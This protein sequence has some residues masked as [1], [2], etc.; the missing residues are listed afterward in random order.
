MLK[1]LYLVRYIDDIKASLGNIVILMADNIQADKII[2]RAQVGESLNRLLSQNY[3]GRSGDSYHF[4]TDEEQDIQKEIKA[5]MVDTSNIVGKIAHMI[6]GAIYE[7]KKF[8]YGKYDFAFD[9][10][11]DSIAVGAVTGGMR[12]RIITVAVDKTEKSELRMMAES[13]G[14]AIVVLSETPY[15]DSLECAEKIRK[16]IKQKI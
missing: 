11:V 7:T 4:L 1:L 14:Q 16:Y 8:R 6:F 5:T 10:M 15:F 13:S 9:Q 2:M 12:L 3:I